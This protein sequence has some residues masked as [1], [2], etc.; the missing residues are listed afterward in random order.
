MA[1]L[2]LCQKLAFVG[3]LLHKITLNSNINEEFLK[4]R[5]LLS[6]KGKW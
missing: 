5:E 1:G 4:K 6:N 3:I 2:F